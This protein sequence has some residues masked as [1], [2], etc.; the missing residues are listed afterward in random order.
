M[1]AHA[2]AEC[3]ADAIRFPSQSGA[4]EALVRTLNF[5]SQQFLRQASY[6]EKRHTVGEPL[7]GMKTAKYWIEWHAENQEVPEEELI[8]MIQSDALQYAHALCEQQAEPKDG[9][10]EDGSCGHANRGI[11]NCENAI[12]AAMESLG[13]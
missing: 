8:E 2:S 1:A 10:F 5:Q 9:E 3:A 6:L 7:N 12:R 4:F 13:V 11:G